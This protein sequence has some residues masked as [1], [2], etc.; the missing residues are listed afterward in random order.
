MK[1]IKTKSI[2]ITKN[3]IIIGVDLARSSSYYVKLKNDNYIA[4]Y[5]K[6]EMMEC[7]GL[8][9]NDIEQINNVLS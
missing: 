7:F 3:V 6:S 2:E 4:Q 1:T 8:T 9:Y 5:T